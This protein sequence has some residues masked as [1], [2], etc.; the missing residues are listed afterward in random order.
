MSVTFAKGELTQ[1]ELVT[2]MAGG[3]E[4]QR[5]VDDLEDEPAGVEG[6]A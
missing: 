3:E 2:H 6:I 4:L 1:T 5:L